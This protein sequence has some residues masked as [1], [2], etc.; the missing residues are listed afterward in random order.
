MTAEQTSFY[1]RMQRHKRVLWI[2]LWAALCV[3][4][5]LF[6]IAMVIELIGRNAGA[7][8]LVE[9]FIALVGAPVSAFI[10]FSVVTSFTQTE[11]SITFKWMTIE[12]GGPA[13]PVILWVICFSVVI[14]SLKI[15]W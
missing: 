1:A 13:G 11:G 3:L 15:V 10:A 2:L 6:V 9:H 5:I 8:F 12:F 4:W 14:A 7:Q